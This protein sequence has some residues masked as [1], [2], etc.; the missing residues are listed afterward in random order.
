MYK[1]SEFNDTIYEKLFNNFVLQNLMQY[2]THITDAYEI[3]HAYINNEIYVG[4]EQKA[5]D[6]VIKHWYENKE[7]ICT[8]FNDYYGK[9]P[10]YLGLDEAVDYYA[11]L[12]KYLAC[13]Q[14]LEPYV[15]FEYM[16]AN[17]LA[18]EGTL[19][20]NLKEFQVFTE[21]D[22]IKTFL[23]DECQH[24]RFSFDEITMIEEFVDEQ[25]QQLVN[26]ID[27]DETVDLDDL[28]SFFTAA[29]LVDNN[30]YDTDF[31]LINEQ[32]E[33]AREVFYHP[34]TIKEILE[35]SNKYVAASH[36]ER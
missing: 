16:M 22:E 8:Y 3:E 36:D 33:K 5:I 31:C 9:H 26:E 1:V 10:E 12:L 28:V 6:N 14:Q 24:F 7:K 32:P 19:F 23:V 13:N 21:V 11:N 17:L 4:C 20:D 34:E 30:F 29:G 15:E 2:M 27:E 35:M 18:D 25:Y